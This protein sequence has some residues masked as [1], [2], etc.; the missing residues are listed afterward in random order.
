MIKSFFIFGAEYFFLAS[1]IIASIFFFRQKFNEQRRII[2]IGLL[3]F[4][5]GCFLAFVGNLLYDNPRPFVIDGFTPLIPHGAD[6]GFP[7]NHALLVSLLAAIFWQF[8][9]KVSLL[10]WLVALTVSISRVYVGVHHSID[11]LGS[12]FIAIL[13]VFLVN[14]TISRFSKKIYQKGKV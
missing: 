6:N 13:A 9:R 3:S 12:M 1:F 7:S 10:L 2:I 8:D 4:A 5:L 14:Q 11:V